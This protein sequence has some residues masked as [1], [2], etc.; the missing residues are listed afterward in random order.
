MGEKVIP[1]DA[2][3]LPLTTCRIPGG[4]QVISLVEKQSKKIAQELSSFS[5]M[6]TASLYSLF[7]EFLKDTDISHEILQEMLEVLRGR[8]EDVTF[9]SAQL[10]Q[11]RTFKDKKITDPDNI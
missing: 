1:F 3:R 4:G 11:S 7:R 2:S 9:L 10:R 8:G 5:D 6:S